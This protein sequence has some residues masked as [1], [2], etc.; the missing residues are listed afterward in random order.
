MSA[1][2]I[3][4]IPICTY[5]FI[6]QVLKSIEKNTIR[7]AVIVIDN[8]GNGNW[9]YEPSPGVKRLSVSVIKNWKNVGVNASWNQAKAVCPPCDLVTILN[10]DTFLNS[11]FW[12]RIISVRY[13]YPATAGCICPNIHPIN[14]DNMDFIREKIEEK[15]K[16]P[17]AIHRMRK[18]EGNA[19]TF[20]RPL[21]DTIPPIP[22]ELTTFFGDDWLWW[23]TYRQGNLWYK[24][25]NNVIWH[26]VG[27]SIRDPRVFRDLRKAE[28]AMYVKRIEAIKAA[29]KKALEKKK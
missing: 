28:K 8:T 22:Q 17:P 21:L 20:Y 5:D 24:D 3:C 1:K 15:S 23:W 26:K 12:E 19:M 10:D 13:K 6:D 25:A 11:R 2:I 18:R 4:F 29:D 9:Q 7:P 27:G 14:S 16:L